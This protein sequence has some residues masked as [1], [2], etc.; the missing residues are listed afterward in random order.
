M[1]ANDDGEIEGNHDRKLGGYSAA[2]PDQGT[3]QAVADRLF[4]SASRLEA[5]P[6]NTGIIAGLRGFSR[7]LLN[8]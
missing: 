1:E 7:L 8:Q 5:A 6:Q 2:R 3:A 4:G